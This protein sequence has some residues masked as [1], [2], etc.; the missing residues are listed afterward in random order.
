MQLGTEFAIESSLKTFFWKNKKAMAGQCEHDLK[1]YV[2]V[3]GGG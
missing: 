2:V 3:M 1:N